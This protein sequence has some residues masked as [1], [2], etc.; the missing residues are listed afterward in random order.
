[1]SSRLE[2]IVEWESRGRSAG[3]RVSKLARSLKITPRQLERFFQGAFDKPPKA[4]LDDL[5]IQD[6]VILMRS[7]MLVKE[8]AAQLGFKNSTHFSR[9]F[10]R[11]RATN[12]TSV[13]V[14]RIVNLGENVGSGSQMS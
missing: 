8:V 3:Y 9:A 7:G 11:L 2:R 5:R 1:M 14:S 12:P 13:Q 4:W 6:A 10:K